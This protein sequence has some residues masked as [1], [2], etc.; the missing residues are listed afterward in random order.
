[1]GWPVPRPLAPTAHPVG[2][3]AMQVLK[4]PRHRDMSLASAR[5]VTPLSGIT[6]RFVT[7]SSVVSSARSSGDSPMHRSTRSLASVTNTF[8]FSRRA[9]SRY[10]RSLPSL[11]AS[12]ATVGK[13][14]TSDVNDNDTG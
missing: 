8:R 12:Y 1:M 7:R 2:R 10:T 6:C 11:R 13:M 4:R 5:I 9:T 14:P 3:K